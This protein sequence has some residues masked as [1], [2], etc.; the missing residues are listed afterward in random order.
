MGSNFQIAS[1]SLRRA[2]EPTLLMK[3]QLEKEGETKDIILEAD[4][5]NV[6]HMTEVLEQ[7][8]QEAKSQHCRRI[9]RSI[10]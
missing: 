5:S 10:K 8:L 2:L 7:A 1:R 6:L 9:M 4:P 3:L